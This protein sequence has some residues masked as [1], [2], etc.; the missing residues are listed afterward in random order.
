VVP[1]GSPYAKK[2]FLFSSSP[3][4]RRGKAV[5]ALTRSGHL[6]SPLVRKKR[7][8]SPEGFPQGIR[9]LPI[10]PSFFRQRPGCAV[11]DFSASHRHGILLFSLFSSSKM[12]E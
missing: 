1:T 8:N 4:R 2:G 12:I 6:F 3:A 7:I 5:L 9:S 10:P 11:D